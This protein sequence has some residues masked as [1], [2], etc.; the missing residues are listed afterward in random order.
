MKA[1][2]DYYEEYLQRTTGGYRMFPPA[3]YQTYRRI[4]DGAGQDL[5]MLAE[6]GVHP[7]TVLG[8][9]IGDQIWGGPNQWVKEGRAELRS[10]SSHRYW[11]RGRRLLEGANEF[12]SNLT[13]YT[14]VRSASWADEEELPFIGLSKRAMQAARGVEELLKMIGEL[15]LDQPGWMLQERSKIPRY[16]EIV[17]TGKTGRG[18]SGK[19]K[20]VDWAFCATMLYELFRR[21]TGKPHWGVIARLLH[22]AGYKDFA[23]AVPPEG[24]KAESSDQIVDRWDYKDKIRWRVENRLEDPRVVEGV[25]FNLCRYKSD[26]QRLGH[27]HGWGENLATPVGKTAKKV[28][29]PE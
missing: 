29:F 1:A 22:F 11:Q 24:V 4:V 18:R 15:G 7:R 12:L 16:P 17:Q 3:V 6:G 25:E 8:I 27:Y 14:N 9:V 26:L 19:S 21:K 23:H 2:L 5:M 20:Q 28:I 13:S 10:L